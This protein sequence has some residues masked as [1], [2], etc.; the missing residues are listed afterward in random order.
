MHGLAQGIDD[1][2]ADFG[3]QARDV[4]VGNEDREL[5][6]AEAGHDIVRAQGG[7]DQ[8]DGV[9]QNLV[10]G[11]MAEIVVDPLEAVEVDEQAAQLDAA[12]VGGDDRLVESG[13]E[14]LAVE[15]AGQVIGDRLGVIAAFGLLE[16]GD[17]GHD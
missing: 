3:R 13:L 10:A 7:A 9:A 14:A 8:L 4:H 15:K 11:G 17:V 12:G 16:R 5:V 1:A 6:A 2:L